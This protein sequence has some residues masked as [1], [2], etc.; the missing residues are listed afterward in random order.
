[1]NEEKKLDVMKFSA[2]LEIPAFAIKK[3]KK[4]QDK[5]AEPAIEWILTGLAL[6]V[7]A[8][9]MIQIGMQI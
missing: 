3:A 7:F 9:A 4:K 2:P 1:M 8:I 6:V 5:K